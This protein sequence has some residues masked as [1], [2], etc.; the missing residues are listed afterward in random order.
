MP[1]WLQHQP[2]RRDTF[3]TVCEHQ[4]HNSYSVWDNLLTCTLLSW[5]TEIEET[6]FFHTASVDTTVR[7][8]TTR[9]DVQVY[10]K[11]AEQVG[12]LFG[13]SKQLGNVI[14]N[15]LPEG[16]WGGPPASIGDAG[17][18]L[19]VRHAL[20]DD[21]VPV[22]GI[23]DAFNFENTSQMI[24]GSFRAAIKFSGMNGTRGIFSWQSASEER[25]QSIEM[26]FSSSETDTVHVDVYD[27]PEPEETNSTEARQGSKSHMVD[28]GPTSW[29]SA[30]ISVMD[31]PQE[32]HEYRFD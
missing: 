20:E 9:W 6:D 16:V 23:D 24:Y 32:F 3:W 30:W 31:L 22:A 17:L 27:R 10:N 11:T 7:V 2:Y 29:G 18:Q 28:A 12:R 19:W 8:G 1:L 4:A 14:T 26:S 21:L 13:F 5:Q 15:P 25:R